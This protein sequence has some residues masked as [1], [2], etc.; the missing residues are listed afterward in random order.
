MT[1]PGFRVRVTDLVFFIIFVF[2]FFVFF[3]FALVLNESRPEFENLRRIPLMS[4]LIQFLDLGLALT[5]FTSKVFRVA[6]HDKLI[7]HN[8]RPPAKV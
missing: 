1:V 3:C 7:F 8:I 4:Q 5:H 2:Y 6:N